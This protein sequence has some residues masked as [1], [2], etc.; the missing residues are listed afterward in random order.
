[1]V[2]GGWERDFMEGVLSSLASAHFWNRCAHGPSA[3]R[4]GWSALG[5]GEVPGLSFQDCVLTRPPWFLILGLTLGFFVLC[6]S[7]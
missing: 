1:M 2:Q 6:L 7:H 5:G 4:H 3:R